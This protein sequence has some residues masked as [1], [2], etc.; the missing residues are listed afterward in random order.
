MLLGHEAGC[1]PQRTIY[2]AAAARLRLRDSV[3]G[4]DGV[5]ISY[6]AVSNDHYFRS[7]A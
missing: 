3:K 2:E 7:A 5:E 4:D 1:T 6:G